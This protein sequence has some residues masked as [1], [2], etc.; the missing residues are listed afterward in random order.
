[1]AKRRARSRNRCDVP[2]ASLG[3]PAGRGVARAAGPAAL[4]AAP[5]GARAPR[6]RRARLGLSPSIRPAL[7]LTFSLHHPQPNPCPNQDPR[8]PSTEQLKTSTAAAAGLRRPTQASAAS[9]AAAAA[10]RRSSAAAA[11]AAAAGGSSPAAAVQTLAL[12]Q[13]RASWGGSSTCSSQSCSSQ[14]SVQ[15]TRRNSPG[16]NQQIEGAELEKLYFDFML[17][18]RLFNVRLGLVITAL[19]MFVVTMPDVAALGRDSKGLLA[20]V[21][22]TPA[23]ALALALTPALAPTP[24]PTITLTLTIILTLTRCSAV[25]RSPC[26]A[27]PPSSPPS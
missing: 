19:V 14:S 22:R 24:T 2:Q 16:L 5:S 6:S 1:M 26:S 18:S 3:Q 9:A 7:T 23:P 11:A 17:R 4:A 27:A 10:G 8:R 25:S 13:R 15:S 21:R 12:T 20:Q